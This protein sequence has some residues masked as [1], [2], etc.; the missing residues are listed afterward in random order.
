MKFIYADSLDFVDPGY[1]FKTDEFTPS[2]EPYWGDQ[3]PHE[4][5]GHAPYDGILVSRAVVGDHR[6][7]GKYSESQAMRFR[8]VGARTFLRF[9]GP[10]LD[11]RLLFGDCGAF[12]YV[13][14]EEPPY[15]PEE[16]AEFY[17]DSGFT[18]GFSVD[19]IIFDFFPQAKSFWDG[20]DEGSPGKDERYRRYQL[21]LSL[22]ERFWAECQRLQVASPQ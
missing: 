9:T 2:R 6:V 7:A 16:M 1:D 21:T 22:A 18:H 17:E 12:S 20:L 11:D 10:S 5:L 19:H 3:Y 15:Q 14:Q 13:Q 8:L 4:I